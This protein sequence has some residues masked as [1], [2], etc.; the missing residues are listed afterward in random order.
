M[1]YLLHPRKVPCIQ[2]SESPASQKGSCIQ[3]SESSASQKG[4]CIQIS[5]SPVSQKEEGSLSYKDSCILEGFPYL[6]YLYL[7]YPI[8]VHVINISC[9]LQKGSCILDLCI[10]RIS[11]RR[12]THLCETIMNPR[13]GRYTVRSSTLFGSFNVFASG[14]SM[15]C[16]PAAYRVQWSGLIL[17]TRDQLRKLSLNK[18]LKGLHTLFKLT[19][20]ELSLCH[21][22]KYL[23]SDFNR[24]RC[25]KHL[26]F[27]SFI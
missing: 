12:T 6:R 9:I 2:I 8:R 1:L 25:C 27:Y 5:E 21:K 11:G 3:I 18:C 7:L 19:L 17:P 13:F 4:S 24:T 15:G 20:K 26:I 16:L 22:L 10:W 23:N 14:L